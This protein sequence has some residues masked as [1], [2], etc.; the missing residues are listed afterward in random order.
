MLPDGWGREASQV[1]SPKRKRKRKTPN[2]ITPIIT[3]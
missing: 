2:L 3:A 1:V